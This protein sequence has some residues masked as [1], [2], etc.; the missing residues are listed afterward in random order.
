M[1]TRRI[2]SFVVVSA[3]PL[4]FTPVE[5]AI[6]EDYRVNLVFEQKLTTGG[7][8][9]YSVRASF[10]RDDVNNKIIAPNGH[11]FDYRNQY[12]EPLSS[13]QFWAM[14]FGQWTAETAL[15]H[16][17][18]QVP[19]IGPDHVAFKTPVITSPVPG[20]EVPEEFTINWQ[21]E[22]RGFVDVHERTNL[23][24]RGSFHPAECCSTTLRNELLNP[25]KGSLELDVYTR[26]FLPTPQIVSQFPLGT[27]SFT[28]D[29][30]V[31]SRTA[32]VTYTVVPEPCAA[33]LIAMTAFAV[34]IIRQR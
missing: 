16:L 20:S 29:A 22:D 1:H 24:S 27:E 30:I 15:S 11:A 18:F 10:S 25:G 12:A 2:S 9:L 31:R 6:S 34:L 7:Q 3:V 19:A 4:L 32:H 23:I 5:T 14:A 26:T 28:L 13:Q 33:L 21:G 8:K 17:V